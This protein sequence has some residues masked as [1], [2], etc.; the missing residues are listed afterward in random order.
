MWD[1]S[2]AGYKACLT[3]DMDYNTDELN[4]DEVDDLCM[5]YNLK[6]R[7][8][9]NIMF[10]FSWCS[11]WY[12]KPFGHQEGQSIALFHHNSGVFKDIRDDLSNFHKQKI[13][14]YTPVDIITYINRHDNY[15]YTVERIGKEQ[16]TRLEKA[17]KKIKKQG[18]NNNAKN[19]YTNGVVRKKKTGKSK[20][21][22][23]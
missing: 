10:V 9:G 8:M 21:K 11:K 15:K 4:L 1:V 3:T 2:D 13:I 17:Y 6:W 19:T 23:I 18:E 22:R 20:Q 12:F 5:K 7:L 16:D 14:L